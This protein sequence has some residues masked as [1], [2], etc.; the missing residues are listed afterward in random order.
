[1]SGSGRECQGVPGTDQADGEPLHL[2]LGLPV[3]EPAA[4]PVGA[5]AGLG[6]GEDG[7]RR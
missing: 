3:A 5:G 2:G 7:V 1:M 6:S 4:V